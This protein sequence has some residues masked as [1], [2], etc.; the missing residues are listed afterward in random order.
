MSIPKAFRN[1]KTRTLKYSAL[2]VTSQTIDWGHNGGYPRA[3]QPVY[4][5]VD[6]ETL[7]LAHDDYGLEGGLS[8]D[9]WAALEHL[10]ETLE[11]TGE[12]VLQPDDIAD[13]CE[14]AEAVLNEEAELVREQQGENGDDAATELEDEACLYGT[15]ASSIDDLCHT[16]QECLD[17]SE[18]L[19]PMMNYFYPLPDG[20]DCED[21]KTILMYGGCLTIIEFCEDEQGTGEFALALTG[22]GMD[23]TDVIAEGFVLLGYYPPIHFC[24][25]PAMA[26]VDYGREA[27]GK[28]TSHTFLAGACMRSLKVRQQ[29]LKRVAERVQQTTKW[30]IE[31]QRKRAARQAERMMK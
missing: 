28:P 23:L 27:D 18:A 17:E 20:A 9:E 15:A 2:D 22:G 29:Q 6:F 26:G 14:T 1:Y 19:Y 25:L 24:D 30:S 7:M 21:A 10:Y 16:F 8:D 4:P 5:A 13:A 11:R 3:W 31:D 12:H